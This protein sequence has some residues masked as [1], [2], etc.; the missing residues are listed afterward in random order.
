MCWE[1]TCVPKLTEAKPAHNI[2][3]KSR[4]TS[5]LIHE[6]TPV[7]QYLL[8]IGLATRYYYYNNNDEVLFVTKAE[9]DN[10]KTYNT[11]KI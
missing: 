6:Q 5:R 10:I 8:R 1:L 3:I 4:L 11:I 7:K 9:H 2:K